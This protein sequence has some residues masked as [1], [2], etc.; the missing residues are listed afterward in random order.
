MVGSRVRVRVRV[1]VRLG[2]GFWVGFGV[3]FGVGLGRISGR[4][5]RLSG[6]GM[7]QGEDARGGCEDNGGGHEGYTEGGCNG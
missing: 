6:L 4:R 2:V 1:R 3:G 7:N 5:D